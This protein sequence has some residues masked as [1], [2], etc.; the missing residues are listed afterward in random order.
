LRYIA[1]KRALANL[2]QNALRYTSGEIEVFTGVDSEMVYIIVSDDGDGIPTRDIERL[3][4]PFTQGD[5]ARGSEGS[6]LGLA[7]IKRIIDAHGGRVELSNKES[8]G[9]QAKLS[10]PLTL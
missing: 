3:F 2:I 8:G 6:G 10:L 4:Q 7:I 5:T 9:L 1:L